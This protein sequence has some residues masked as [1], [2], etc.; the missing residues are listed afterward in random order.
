MDS[1][2]SPARENRHFGPFCLHFYLRF[3]G[4]YAIINKIMPAGCA[5]GVSRRLHRRQVACGSVPRRKVW[6]SRLWFGEGHFFAEPVAPEASH[7]WQ[8]SEEE[9]LV[10]A[11]LAWRKA[12]PCWAGCTGGVPHV[13]ILREGKFGARGLGSARPTVFMVLRGALIL[14]QGSAPFQ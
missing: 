10:L 2:V 13:A 1:P 9:S 4:N 5:G 12:L 3:S 11:A 7:V 6:C 14:F 8:R